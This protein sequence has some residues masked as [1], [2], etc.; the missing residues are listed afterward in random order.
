MT[1][2]TD[3]YNACEEH[4]SKNVTRLHMFIHHQLFM[5]NKVQ[6][7]SKNE[8]NKKCVLASE[9]GGTK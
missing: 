5:N 3:S 4:N 6:Q 1:S 8:T 7:Y 9:T 2:Y